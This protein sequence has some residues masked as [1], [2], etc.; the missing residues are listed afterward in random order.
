MGFQ[1]GIH[2]D[3]EKL[4]AGE[5]PSDI[6]LVGLGGEVEEVPGGW[7][8]ATVCQQYGVVG[9]FE[10]LA[11]NAKATFLIPDSSKNVLR[12]VF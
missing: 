4:L 1:V 11:A 10:Q 12:E 8:S 7:R 3:F 2:I 5:L 9:K 6:P